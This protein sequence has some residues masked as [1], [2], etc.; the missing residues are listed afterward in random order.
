[1]NARPASVRSQATL[2]ALLLAASQCT[3]CFSANILHGAVESRSASQL[4]SAHGRLGALW[5]PSS[6]DL[7]DTQA[8]IRA[9]PIE[10]SCELV[11]GWL[12]MHVGA[13]A[14]RG[15]LAGRLDLSVSLCTIL[16]DDPAD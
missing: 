15:R 11:H 6:A 1:M 12:A 2:A 13:V 14:E 5:F 3:S 7:P 10:A 4:A 9:C 16:T 8:S